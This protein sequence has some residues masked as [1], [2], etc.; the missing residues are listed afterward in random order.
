[1]QLQPDDR[2]RARV[3]SASGLH[4]GSWLAAFPVTMHATARARHYQ[5]ALAMRLGLEL[6]ELL[7]VQG[8]PVKCGSTACGGVH[9]AFAFHP[10]SCRAGNRKGLWTMRHNALELMLVH[11]VRLLGYAVQ[12]CSVGSGNWFGT[13]GFDPVT[14]TYKRA[15]VVLPHYLGPGRH[16]FLDTAITDPASIGALRATPSSAAEAGV[17]ASLRAEKKMNK[18]GPL[19]A[20]VSSTFRPAVVERYG[21]CCD[22]LVGFIKTLCGDGDRDA[23]R[24]D[25]YTFSQSSRTTY[26]ASL[27]TFSAVIA[28]A[29]MVER[30]ISMDVAAAAAARE[31]APRRVI[32]AAK[33]VQSPRDVEGM[34]G[35]FWY[36]LFDQ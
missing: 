17:A 14:K 26:M 20:G 35:R 23:L 21:A 15:D 5:L 25:D 32:R 34:G 28:D 33:R 31:N 29:A 12:S 9:D 24:V 7:A 22:S 16:L 36:E 1:M 27:L 3:L 4:A 6:P 2:H 18:Y 10:A 8:N 13:A 30:V 11:V 19:T